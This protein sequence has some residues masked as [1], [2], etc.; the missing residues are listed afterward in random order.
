MQGFD[1]EVMLTEGNNF[2]NDT[3]GDLCLVIRATARTAAAS[4][5][6]FPVNGSCSQH[7][8]HYLRN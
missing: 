3:N 1:D 8:R 4:V 6:F 7:I 5:A 2:S